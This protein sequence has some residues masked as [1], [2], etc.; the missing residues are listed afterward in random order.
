M[1]RPTALIP[2]L[3]LLL[4]LTGGVLPAAA[5]STKAWCSLFSAKDSSGALP[6]PVRCTFS[7]RQGNVI[8][9]MPKR[10]FDFPAKEQGKSYQRDNHSAGIGFSKEGEFTLVVFWQDPRLQ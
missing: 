5:D 10:Q 3:T 4:S 8:V 2:A 6:E 1:R 7:Q 9:S